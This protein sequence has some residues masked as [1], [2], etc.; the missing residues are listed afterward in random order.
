MVDAALGVVLRSFSTPRFIEKIPRTGATGRGG[1]TK[2]EEVV[3]S[4]NPVT[5]ELTERRTRAM[6][7]ISPSGCYNELATLACVPRKKCSKVL[8][9]GVG[10]CI[11]VSLS[12]FQVVAKAQGSTDRPVLTAVRVDCPILLSGLLDDPLW[13]SV[14]PIELSYEI[15]PGENMPAP[16]R[17]EVVALFDEDN[18]YFGFRCHDSHPENIRANLSDRDKIFSDDYVVV[19]IDTYGDF[20]RGYELAVNPYGVQADLMM[21]INNEDESFDMLWE[22]KA[23]ITPE[24]W[25]AEM[26]IPFKS[27]RFPSTAVQTWGLNIF[28][29][30]PRESRILTHWGPRDRSKPNVMTEGGVL[31]GLRDIRSG[32]L[33]EVLPYVMGEKGGGKVDESDPASEFT[34]Q[35]WEG[36]C[37]A[38]FK[39]APS[40]DFALDL[41]VNPDFSQ[42]E[43]DADQISVNTTF[44]LYYSE[45]RPFFL[46]SR[47]LLQTPM[48]YSRSINNPL[49][50]GRVVGKSG[51]LSYLFLTAYDRNT[52]FIIPGDER[53]NTVI[54]SLKSNANIGRLRYNFEDES[55]V[56]GMALTRNLSQ[57][58]NYVAGLDWRYKFWTNCYCEGEWYTSETREINDTT[59][60]KSNRLFGA[61]NHTATLDGEEYIGQGIRV[62]LAHVGKAFLTEVVYEDLSPTYQAYDGIITL[63]D[64]RE[65]MVDQRYTRYWDEGFIERFNLYLSGRMRYNHEGEEKEKVLMPM[66]SGTLKGQTNIAIGYLLVN[67]EVFRGIRLSGVRRAQF[68]FSTSPLNVLSASLTGEIGKFIYRSASPEI[69]SGHNLGASLTIRPTSMLSIDISYNRARLWSHVTESLLYDGYVGRAVGVCQFSKEMFLRTIVQYNSFE[70]TMNVYPLFSYKLNALTTFFVGYRND[71]L[72][73]GSSVGFETTR[74]EFFLKLQYLFRS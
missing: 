1:G 68:N 70:G 31:K 74:T 40:S 21:T 12:F 20:Q 51:R 14:T 49:V 59:L 64:Y 17:T 10:L 66:I 44:A 50:A 57:G 63:V 38:G 73:Y 37:G 7:R 60:F 72:D 29:S 9:R 46:E 3:G 41:V 18:L 19:V 47:E 11:A 25:I 24:G 43:S 67:E 62:A 28:R 71:W 6:K 58:H 36:R 54:T 16:E 55:Y 56:G 61:T 30:I 35:P 45:K 26:K 2:R 34:R 33:Y 53:S 5:E 23:S 4:I 8:S 48:Y 52:V 32:G 22:S 69:G 15:Q 13:K 65:L 27:L 42:I 39:Y